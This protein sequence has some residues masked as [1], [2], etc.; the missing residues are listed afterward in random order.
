M[1]GSYKETILNFFSIFKLYFYFREGSPRHTL[2]SALGRLH[3]QLGD[4]AGAEACFSEA[5]EIRGGAPDVREYV[6]KGLIAV[7]QNSFSDAYICFK[8]ASLLEP[9]NVMVIFICKKINLC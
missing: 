9:S 8:Q 4:V 5:I 3:L 2:L 1:K 7:A 6:D